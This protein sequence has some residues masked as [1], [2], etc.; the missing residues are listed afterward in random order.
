MPESDPLLFDYDLPRELIAQ[1]PLANRADARL[2]VVDRESQSLSHWYVRDLPELLRA[3]DRLVLNDTKVLHATL[4]GTRLKTGGAWQG[5][6]LS[7]EPSGDWRI[8]CK[9]RGTLEPFEKVALVDRENREAEQL[10]LLEK[11]SEGQWLARPE[12]GRP[13]DEVLA[14]VGRVPLPHYIRD[15]KMV[16]DDVARYQTVFARKPG[17]VAAPTAGLHF[18]QPLLRQIEGVGVEFAPV[19]L[20]VGLGT[21]RPIKA[22]AVENHTMHAEWGELLPAAAEGINRTKSQGGR[23]VAVGTTAVRT[24]ET[25]AQHAAEGQAV[26]PWSGDTS[27]F[28]RPPHEFRAVDALMTNFHFPRT[29]LLLLVQAFGGVDL[30]RAAYREAIKERYRFYSYG[31]AML[32]V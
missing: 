18:T 21:F 16:D 2:M 17:A 12:S 13:L 14:R 5:L 6:F 19:T 4:A 27:L 32:I 24:L 15:G 7:A 22:D 20:H 26:A 8:V 28:I 10:W 23:V 29:T 30:V 31:D 11:L 1:E 3:G 9:T 25:A